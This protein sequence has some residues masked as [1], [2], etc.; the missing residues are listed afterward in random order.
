ML[1]SKEFLKQVSEQKLVS[2]IFE[3]SCWQRLVKPVPWIA[4]LTVEKSIGCGLL[5][6]WFS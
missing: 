2:V 3:S 6:G 4:S 5:R 1:W